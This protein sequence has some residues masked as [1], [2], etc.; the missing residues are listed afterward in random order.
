MII[1]SHDRGWKV[2]YYNGKWVYSDGCKIPL[3]KRPCKLCGK[4]PT[5]EGYDACIGYVK[6]A[7]SI[8]CGHGIEKNK[9]WMVK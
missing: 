6:G 4:P 7:T 3:G 9:I 5:K 2:I 8:C 1:T